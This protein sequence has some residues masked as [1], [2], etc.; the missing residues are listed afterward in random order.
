MNFLNAREVEETF[1]TVYE[2]IYQTRFLGLPIVNSLLSVKVVGIRET[3]DF[4]SFCL[5]TPWMINKILVLKRDDV[6]IHLPEEMRMDQLEK[7]G[8]FYLINVFSPTDKFTSMQKA[9]IEGEK[10]AEKLYVNILEENNDQP[11]NA[12]RREFLHILW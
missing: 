3:E 12:S 5:I 6:N 1:Q 8:K 11:Q 2:D 7:L 9:I 10:L 4:Y